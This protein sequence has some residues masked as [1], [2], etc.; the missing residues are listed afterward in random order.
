[1]KIQASKLSVLCQGISL[2]GMGLTLSSCQ[3][4][5]QQPYSSTDWSVHSSVTKENYPVGVSL[6]KIDDAPM[7]SPD[8]IAQGLTDYQG[9]S[10]NSEAITPPATDLSVTS[11]IPGAEPNLA[12]QDAN[13]PV[14]DELLSVDTTMPP[15]TVIRP[16][17]S[18]PPVAE[19]KIALSIPPT[20]IRR[21][22][23]NPTPENHALMAASTVRPPTASSQTTVAPKSSAPETVAAAQPARLAPDLSE[24]LMLARQLEA[25]HKPQ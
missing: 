21:A 23:I 2:A 25:T 9:S 18:L 15:P 6:E 17:L 20:E 19:P 8:Q 1:M 13:H 14:T 7:P 16:A 3:L 4:P 12:A 24:I 11:T 10:T 22:E 5:K